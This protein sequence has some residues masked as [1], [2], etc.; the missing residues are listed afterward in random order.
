[1]KI[2]SNKNII[3]DGF[4]AELV[5][6]AIFTGLLEIPLIRKPSE[7]II[8]KSMIPFSE[9]NKSVN[10]EEFICFYE[11]DIRFR[12]ILTA[13][14]EQLASLKKFK[15]VISPDCSLYYD[16]PLVLQMANTYLNRQIGHYLQ[17]QGLYV[18][19]NVRWGDERTYKRLILTELPFAFL[20][21][22][23]RGI[24]SKKH[25]YRKNPTAKKLTELMNGNY[26]VSKRECI[27]IPYVITTK[28]DI[29]VGRRNGNGKDGDPTPHPT[30]IGGK[31]PKVKCAGI[32]EIAGGKIKSIDVNSGHFKP[33][34]KSLPE[35]KKILEKLPKKLFHKKY[36]WSK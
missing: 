15:G 14:K 29:I 33:N 17:E 5:E 18:I 13:T 36:E 32:L 34:K 9:R 6:N 7:F 22:E 2:K 25:G 26:I 11:H 31:N 8:P 24:Y 35:A 28:G 10:H 30:L 16:M 21:L 4:N 20:G 3:D 1:M 23:K 19:P 12:D 27:H